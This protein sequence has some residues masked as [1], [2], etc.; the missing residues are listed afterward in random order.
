MKQWYMMQSKP[1][2]G[3]SSL[4]WIPGAIG[5]V[6]FGAEPA[7]IIESIL[8]TIRLMVEKIVMNGLDAKI[9][10]RRGAVVSICESHFLGYKAIF[11]WSLSGS[12]CI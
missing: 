11:D 8:N 9:D 1:Q 4:Q 10:Q 12:E 5:L 3:T 6:Y 7:Y 2:I